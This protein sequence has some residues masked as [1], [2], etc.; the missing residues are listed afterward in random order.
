[1][2]AIARVAARVVAG[3][4]I[5]VAL[6]YAV[7]AAWVFVRTTGSSTAHTQR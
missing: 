3:V 7:D 1:M 2:H 6:V 4:V 5:A